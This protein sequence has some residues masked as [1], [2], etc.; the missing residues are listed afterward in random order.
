ML[1]LRIFDN[2]R[3]LI[4]TCCGALLC[5]ALAL[6]GPAEISLIAFPAIGLFASIMWPILVSPASNSVSEH[7][8]SFAGILSTGT[9]GG[10]VVR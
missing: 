8:G 4:G 10:A 3:L 9:M 7:H 2:R 6:F 1:L 5:L